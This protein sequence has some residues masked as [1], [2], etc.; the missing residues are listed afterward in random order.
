MWIRQLVLT[1]NIDCWHNSTYLK[2]NCFSIEVYEQKQI[3]KTRTTSFL[4]CSA[5]AMHTK[6]QHNMSINSKAEQA[7]NSWPAIRIQ[8]PGMKAPL[9]ARGKYANHKQPGK[10]SKTSARIQRPAQLCCQLQSFYDI[11]VSA[12]GKRGLPPLPRGKCQWKL[13]RALYAEPANRN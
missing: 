5:K 2:K 1:S 6:E 11:I 10:M 9:L 8:P 13:N 4:F 12:L 3:G 7:I